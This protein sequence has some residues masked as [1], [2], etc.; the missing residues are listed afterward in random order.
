MNLVNGLATKVFDF[1]MWPLELL[2]LEVA[3]VIISGVFGV[4]ALVAF[5]YMSSQKGIAAA[6]D[7]IK[8][9]MIEIRIYQDDLP[10]VGKAVG[11][12]LMRNFQYMG[13]NFLPFI[14]LS[15]PF[16]I[17]ISQLAVRYGFE[18]LPANEPFTMKVALAEG[19][20]GQVRELEVITPDWV[21]ES[22]LVVVRGSDGNAYVSVRDAQPGQW[23]FEFRLGSGEVVTK[24]VVVGSREDAPK[25]MQPDRVGDFWESWLWPAEKTLTS[26]G[27]AK[28]SIV[29]GYPEREYWWMP[30]GPGGI[31]IGVILYSLVIGAAA[32][33]PLGVTI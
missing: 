23:D 26:T 21:D 27:F 1:I 22:E 10:V 25:T 20:A 5:K 11:K 12:I 28:I 6:K 24:Q 9:H 16:V 8:G 3:F 15:V 17:L 32:M 33:K 18:P 7:K 14:P 29:G 19:N 4:L 30:A 2:G 13:L 31:L